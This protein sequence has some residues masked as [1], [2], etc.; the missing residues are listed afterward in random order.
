MIYPVDQTVTVDDPEVTYPEEEV[1]VECFT[2]AVCG[3]VGLGTS[4]ESVP[5]MTS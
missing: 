2:M 4:A 3:T 1:G 5:Y